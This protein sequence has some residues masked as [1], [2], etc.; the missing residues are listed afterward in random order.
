M[1][2]FLTFHSYP[3]SEGPDHQ[4]LLGIHS[5][6]QIAVD[7]LLDRCNRPV[8]PYES[9]YIDEYTV[10][11]GMSNHYYFTKNGIQANRMFH[12]I[13]T[14]KYISFDFKKIFG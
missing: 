8:C 2:V 9:F 5:T 1:H 3:V 4:R 11:D 6:L 7:M 13:P 14:A 12:W 10:D